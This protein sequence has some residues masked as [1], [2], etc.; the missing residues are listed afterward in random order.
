[1]K[2]TVK[3]MMAER[4]ADLAKLLELIESWSNMSR[5]Y[6]QY[7]NEYREKRDALGVADHMRTYYESDE[8]RASG[9][10]ETYHR[11]AHELRV[12]LEPKDGDHGDDE[13]S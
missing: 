7:A 13:R 5:Y 10:A 9:I 8:R 2:K 4:Q 6:T 1:M 11:C 3:Q 12:L